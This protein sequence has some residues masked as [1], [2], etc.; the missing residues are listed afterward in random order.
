[1]G[2]QECEQ[3]AHDE[4]YTYFGEDQWDDDAPPGCFYDAEEGGAFFNRATTGGAG[5]E[6]SAFCCWSTA[7]P[8]ATPEP[9]PEP[10]KCISF[11][12]GEK[13]VKECP[14]GSTVVATGQE[15]EQG[16]NDEGYTYFGEDQWDDDAPPGCFYD[17]E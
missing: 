12:E 3:G 5:P 16:A 4:G 14:A 17:A 15:C 1:M 7:S 11:V 9:T 10:E 13:N 2:G 6:R 8:A